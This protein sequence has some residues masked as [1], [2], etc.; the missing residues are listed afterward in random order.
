MPSPTR[1]AI[2]PRVT[3]TRRDPANRSLA[4]QPCTC[5]S[6]PWVA[7][8]TARATSSSSCGPLVTTTTS[9]TGA[10]A[11]TAAPSASKS[12]K[13]ST[14]TP[15]VPRALVTRTPTS[16]PTT[17]QRSAAEWLTGVIGAITQPT[18][19]S[20]SWY[21][22]RATSSCSAETGRRVSAPMVA[23]GRPSWSATARA[24]VSSP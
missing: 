23:T 16:C 3:N 18:R 22:D 14:G 8:R 12:G 9:G 6:A 2:A 17:A 13:D 4:S 10:P 21:A 19:N 11:A 7:V 5:S 15:A 1:V 20:D 24:T